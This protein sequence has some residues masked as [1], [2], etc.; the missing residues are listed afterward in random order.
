MN[1]KN[2]IKR[3]VYLVD[4]K[5]FVTNRCSDYID[6]QRIRVYVENEKPIPD[7]NGSIHTFQLNE[8]EKITESNQIKKYIK[9]IK[10]LEIQDIKNPLYSIL[11]KSLEGQQ[12]LE[13]IVANYMNTSKKINIERPDEPRDISDFVKYDEYIS[14]KNSKWISND[15]LSQR[16]K[17]DPLVINEKIPNDQCTY[18]IRLEDADSL[19]WLYVGQTSNLLRRLG[20]HLEQ[21]GDSPSL[22]HKKM[23]VSELEEIRVKGDES[24]HY[25]DAIEKYNIPKNRI[26]GGK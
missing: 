20:N 18:I 23:R 17:Q 22:N 26:K 21:G 2:I 8:I 24:K 19:E 3:D 6:T 16:R 25:Q 1:E 9:Q 15:Y 5:Y 13:Y 14:E 12:I 10:N 11:T 7:I 4:S